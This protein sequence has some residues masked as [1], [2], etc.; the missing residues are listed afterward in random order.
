LGKSEE[1]MIAHLE[2]VSRQIVEM[3]LAA[4][5]NLRLHAGLSL[6]DKVW[7]A[8]GTLQ[9]ARRLTSEEAMHLLSL[10]RLGTDMKLLP[11]TNFHFMATLV[12][13]NPGCLQYIL[14]SELDAEQR[15]DQR[16]RLI[17]ETLV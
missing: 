1:G 2:A 5:E 13:S 3:E 7:R 10:H 8:R 16:A 11:D 12:N 17:R 15:D 6:E 14:G 4:R 9:N